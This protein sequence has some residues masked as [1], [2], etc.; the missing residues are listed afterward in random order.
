MQS[1]LKLPDEEYEQITIV[2][3]QLKR[4]APHDKLGIV[5]VLL[6]M[7]SGKI[8]H[9]EIQVLEQD[10]MPERITY[11]NAKMLVIQLKAG[12]G[13]DELQNTVS[14]A[15][16]DFEIVKDSDEKYHHVFHIREEET[17][18]K[19]TD[20]IEINALELP[21]IPKETDNTKKCE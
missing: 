1:V 20:L 15:I 5:D 21:K 6:N 9:I 10:D 14:I 3:P 4:E 11:Y 17:G 7:K 18:I 16:A 2:D 13:Y 12:Q 19:F 8:V